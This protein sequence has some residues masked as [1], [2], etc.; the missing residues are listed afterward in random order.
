MYSTFMFKL[1]HDL[2][3][4]QAFLISHYPHNHSTKIVYKVSHN[5]WFLYDYV[6]NSGC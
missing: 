6:K 2:D 3:L 1:V 4:P 5:F